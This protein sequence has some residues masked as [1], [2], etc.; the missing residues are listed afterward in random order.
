MISGNVLTNPVTTFQVPN[1]GIIT[2]APSTFATRSVKPESTDDLKQDMLRIAGGDEQRAA[3]LEDVAK[4]GGKAR[5]K[6]LLERLRD[7]AGEHNSPRNQFTP[8]YAPENQFEPRSYEELTSNHKYVRVG[9]THPDHLQE[10]ENKDGESIYKFRTHVHNGESTTVT[11]N[12]EL[13]NCFYTQ[14][15]GGDTQ[16][17]FHSVYR[18]NP[19]LAKRTGAYLNECTGIGKFTYSGE[20]DA[21]IKTKGIANA[22]IFRLI[23]HSEGLFFIGAK[24]T[25]RTLSVEKN[26]VE[27]YN[28]L[29]DRGKRF[30]QSGQSPFTINVENHNGDHF[31]TIKASCDY[32]Q[33]KDANN[34]CDIPFEGAQTPLFNATCCQEGDRQLQDTKYLY[35]APLERGGWFNVKFR[36]TLPNFKWKSDTA[37]GESKVNILING[38]NVANTNARVGNNNWKIGDSHRYYSEPSGYHAQ[39]GIA[40]ASG[41]MVVKIQ[42]PKINS[43]LS[44]SSQSDIPFPVQA[45]TSYDFISGE[46]QSGNDDYPNNLDGILKKFGLGSLP[47]LTVHP[48]GG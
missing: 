15:K 17:L 33:F 34:R 20:F 47:A 30:G 25:I 21:N 14:G 41:E 16:N 7:A 2:T 5:F 48:E 32:A 29:V 45:T 3:L 10:R 26:S 6:Q 18:P 31:L 37:T 42:D 11:N 8:V 35:V 36:M 38:E 4:D 23:P 44:T 43:Y 27:D 24:N 28:R 22:T 1:A 9:D 39:F 13:S 46:C 12:I 40:D 19:E